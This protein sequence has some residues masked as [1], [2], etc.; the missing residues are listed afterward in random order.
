MPNLWRNTTQN[1]K[2][3]RKLFVYM[4]VDGVPVTSGVCGG[5][6]GQISLELELQACEHPDI[7]AGNQTQV[8]WQSSN[9]S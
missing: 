7:G 2:L 6:W 8:P 4:Y 3:E 5:Q 9:S 1:H